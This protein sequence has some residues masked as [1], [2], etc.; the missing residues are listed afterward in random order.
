MITAMTYSNECFASPSR[1]LTDSHEGACDGFDGTPAKTYFYGPTKE[2]VVEVFARQ[3]VRVT[4]TPTIRT[5]SWAWAN[6]D[7]AF[8]WAQERSAHMRA[9]GWR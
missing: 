7:H 4:Y 9:L 1:A 2:I 5:V 6:R 8:D 3:G